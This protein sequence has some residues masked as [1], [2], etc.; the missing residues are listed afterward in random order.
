MSLLKFGDFITENDQPV[1]TRL[2]VIND[3]FVAIYPRAEFKPMVTYLD[4][5]TAKIKATRRFAKIPDIGNAYV[6]EDEKTP[7]EKINSWEFFFTNGIAVDV[8]RHIPPENTT[9]KEPRFLLIFGRV[10]STDVDVSCQEM[11]ANVSTITVPFFSPANDTISWDD[12]LRYGDGIDLHNDRIKFAIR[13]TEYLGFLLD[14]LGELPTD[15]INDKF[16]IFGNTV[17]VAETTYK[18]R[19][20]FYDISFDEC[21]SILRKVFARTWTLTT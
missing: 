1:T 16:R 15:F 19:F 17:G 11:L 6:S 14:V 18:M 12:E 7:N 4:A 8:R 13:E 21:Y 20:Y 3:G 9:S 10:F 5:H 2:E